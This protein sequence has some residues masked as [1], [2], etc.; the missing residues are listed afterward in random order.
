MKRLK[1]LFVDDEQLVLDALRR[2]LPIAGAQWDCCFVTGGEQALTELA[3]QKFDVLVTDLCMPGTSGS[4]LLKQVAVSHPD[5]AQVVLSGADEDRSSTASYMG[6][7]QYLTKPC[8][9]GDLITAIERGF[10]L[11]EL[12]HRYV[13]DKLF[14]AIGEL[15]TVTKLDISVTRDN[16]ADE[17]YIAEISCPE[18]GI[19]IRE[20]CED[21]DLVE[22]IEPAEVA[23]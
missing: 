18:L 5:V 14:I 19:S 15:S 21:P 7:V 22:D 2:A 10:V 6:C 23:L 9:T 3:S 13:L 4:R 1:V 12:F 11:K 20:K 17:G 16:A 8:E